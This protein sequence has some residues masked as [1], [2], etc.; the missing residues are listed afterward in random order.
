VQVTNCMGRGHTEAA[1]IGHTACFVMDRLSTSSEFN[2]LDFLAQRLEH[3]YFTGAWKPFWPDIFAVVISD[4]YRYDW[5]EFCTQA[6]WV[7][8]PLPLSNG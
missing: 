2:V 4:S 1:A 3:A 7:Q 5:H 6:R 8:S